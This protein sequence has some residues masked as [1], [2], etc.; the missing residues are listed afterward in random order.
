MLFLSFL[1]GNISWIR[2][3]YKFYFFNILFLILTVG[4]LICLIRN[5]EKNGL[6]L[7]FYIMLVIFISVIVNPETWW[8]RYIPQLWF[9][10]VCLIPLLTYQSYP[11]LR[12]G[13]Y[14][15]IGVFL[16][17]IYIIAS[18]NFQ[19]NLRDTRALNNQLKKIAAQHRLVDVCFGDFYSNRVRF[20]K[21][22]IQYRE[23]KNEKELESKGKT[24]IIIWPSVK[25]RMSLE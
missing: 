13:K 7:V 24:K 16:F 14:L 1:N 21:M 4:C 3:L 11:A 8:A 18:V 20:E 5:Q 23:F 12:V 6:K 9:I 2:P 25:V 15:L 17:N 19:A 22:G 10:P